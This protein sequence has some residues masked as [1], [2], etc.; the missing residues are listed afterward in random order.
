MLRACF[1]VPQIKLMGSYGAKAQSD[2]PVI[3]NLVASGKLDLTSSVTQ[4]Y[5]LMDAG[6]AYNLLHDGQV[7]GRA[8]IDMEL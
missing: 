4:K 3:I 7:S 2:L 1:S 8:V 6:Y 5:K